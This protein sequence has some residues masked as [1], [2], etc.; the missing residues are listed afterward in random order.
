MRQKVGQTLTSMAHGQSL[1]MWN[2]AFRGANYHILQHQRRG[3]A[4]DKLRAHKSAEP[5][6]ISDGMYSHDF[7]FIP[8]V[9]QHY[10]RHIPLMSAANPDVRR[11]RGE[12]H[13]L[14]SE[15]I[16][17]TLVDLPDQVIR[18]P[19]TLG[20][21]AAFYFMRFLRVFTHAFFRDKYNHHA[22]TLETIAAVPPTVAAGLRHFESLRRLRHDHGWVHMLLEEAENERVHLFTWM[23]VTKPTFIERSLVILAQIV[24]TTFYTGAYI[25]SPAWCHRLT[26]YLEEEATL[27]YTAYLEAIDSGKLPNGPAPDIAKS[28]WHLSDDATIRDVVLCIRA[29]EMHHRDFNHQLADK[30]RHHDLSGTSDIPF[31]SN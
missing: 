18:T 25:V 27:A 16:D 10:H 29:D 31:K 23:E 21:K 8:G 15:D 2:P 30:I 28:Y 26:G 6:V 17:K 20:D 3:Y 24:Y 19:E 22:V 7:K 14:T 4:T 13:R 5:T 11:V 1:S 12:A 9:I